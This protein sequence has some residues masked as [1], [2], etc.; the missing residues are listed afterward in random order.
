MATLMAYPNKRSPRG[1]RVQDKVLNYQAYFP[2]GRYG[3]PIKA[4]E[5][6]RAAQAKVNERRHLREVR[7]SLDF[8]QIFK[9][10]GTVI[11]L[12]RTQR[13]IN[14]KTINLL[15][16]Q[17]TVN[18]KQIKTDRRINVQNCFNEAYSSIQE[19]ILNQRGIERTH[20]ITTAFKKCA[21]LYRT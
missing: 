19:W 8:N 17:V 14:G 18:G 7:L 2:F 11:G 6:A 5:A 21:Y 20:E 3:C 16:A 10:D 15:V 9:R 13:L 1:F 4:A 12:R